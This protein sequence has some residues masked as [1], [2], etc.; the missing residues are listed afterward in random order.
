MYVLQIRH[1]GDSAWRTYYKHHKYYTAA[2]FAYIKARFELLF[3]NDT[4]LRIHR[5]EEDLN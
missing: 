2:L 3:V 5:I 4:E 1:K